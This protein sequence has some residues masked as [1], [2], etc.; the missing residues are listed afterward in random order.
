MVWKCFLFLHA[1]AGAVTPRVG[2]KEEPRIQKPAKRRLANI[3][4]EP[5]ET[6]AS[7]VI[8]IKTSRE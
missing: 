8:A 6:A 4:R 5:N 7:T 1:A 3:A 2:G